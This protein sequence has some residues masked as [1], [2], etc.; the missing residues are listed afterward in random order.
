M[1]DVATGIT[2]VFGTSGFS[3]AIEDVEPFDLTREDIRTS[4]QGTT[5]AHTFMPTDLYDAGVLSFGIHYDP[6]T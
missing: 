1:A 3:A 4:H 6:D 2:I 5:G